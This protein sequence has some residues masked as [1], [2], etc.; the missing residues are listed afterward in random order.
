MFVRVKS[1]PNSPRKSVQIVQSVSVDDKV[2]QKIV[3][4]VGIALDEAGAYCIVGVKLK[5]LPAALQ[6]KVL[7]KSAYQV[8]GKGASSA[9]RKAMSPLLQST[10]KKKIYAVMGLKATTTLTNCTD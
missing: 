9:P 8:L 4:H 3:C 5:Q 6:T 7:D 2:R 10:Q 1:T